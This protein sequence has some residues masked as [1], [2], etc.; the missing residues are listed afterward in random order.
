MRTRSLDPAGTEGNVSS[1][2][3]FPSSPPSGS[4]PPSASEGKS[5]SIG[6]SNPPSKGSRVSV[7]GE[8]QVKVGDFPQVRLGE[9]ACGFLGG[10]PNRSLNDL[11]RFLLG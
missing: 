2:E 10:F 1:T 11:R 4:L 7:F 6:T 5:S 9:F 8:V 3:A